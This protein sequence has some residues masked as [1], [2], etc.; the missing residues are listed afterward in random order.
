MAQKQLDKAILRIVQAYKKSIE[1]VL[2]VKKVIVFGS[3]AKGTAK[4][5]SDIDVVVVFREVW[6]R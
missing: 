1:N 6:A 5:W 2:D 3:Q 4:S